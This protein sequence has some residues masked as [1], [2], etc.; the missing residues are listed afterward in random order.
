MQHKFADWTA[1]ALKEQLHTRVEIGSINVGFLNN[2]IVNDLYVEDLSHKEMLKVAR[3]SVSINLFQLI[4]N[5]KIAISTA[6]LFGTKANIY[7]QTKDGDF[8][9]QFLADAFKSD[10][11]ESKPIHLQINSLIVR[12]ADFCYNLLYEPRKSSIDPNHLNIKN[13]GFNLS[14]KT[15]TPD[16]VN[17][18]LKR[19]SAKENNCGLVLKELSLKLESNKETSVLSGFTLALPKTNLN[20]DTLRLNH[21]NFD[22]DKSFSFELAKIAATICPSDFLFLTPAVE[23]ADEI[24]HL[25]TTLSGSNKALDINELCITNNSNTLNVDLRAQASNYTTSKPTVDISVTDISANASEIE[26]ITS[27]LLIDNTFLTPLFNA[28]NIRYTGNFTM[29]AGSIMSNG[30]LTT[31]AGTLAYEASMNGEKML[32]AS[33]EAK[34]INLGRMLDDENFGILNMNTEAL[35]DL[36]AGSKIPCGE[37][38]T[39]IHDFDYNGYKY[40]SINIDARNN[41]SDLMV[42]ATSADEN[43]EFDLDATVSNFDTATKSIIA[44]LNIKNLNLKH[45]NIAKNT[46]S[47][48]YSFNLSTKAQ[49]S[50]INNFSGTASADDITLHTKNGTQTI[51]NITLDAELNGS[52]KQHISIASSFIDAEVK[53]SFRIDDIVN[54]FQNVLSYHLPS[55][56]EKK[57][58]SSQSDITYRITYRD[59]ELLHHFINEEYSVDSPITVFGN[60]NSEDHTLNLTCNAPKLTLGTNQLSNININC[61]SSPGKLML[62]FDGGN[63]SDDATTG[64]KIIAIAHKDRVD[65]DIE[66]NNKAKNDLSLSLFATTSFSKHDGLLKT[67]VNIEKSLLCINN[68]DWT[69]SPSNITYSDK[70]VECHNFK[71]SS[72]AQYLEIDGKASPDPGD[73][74]IVKLND[75]EVAYILDLVNFHSVEFG[76]KASGH[77]TM[78]N[79][80]GKPDANAML[81]VQNFTLEGGVMGDANIFARWDKEKDGI[82]VN[83]HITDS[84]MHRIGLS[85]V[86]IKTNG[87]TDVNG[88]ILPGKEELNLDVMTNNTRTDFLTGFIGDIFNDINGKVNGKLNVVGPFEDIN[89]IGDVTADMSFKLAATKVPYVVS[90]DTVHLRYHEFAFEDIKLHDKQNNVGVLNGL[91]THHNLANFTYDFKADFTNLCAY[92]E[93]EFN[94]DKYMAQVWANGDIH[95]YGADGHPMYIDANV[96]PCKGSVFAYDSATPDALIS[97]SF[98]D[99]HDITATANHQS[100]NADSAPAENRRDSQTAETDNYKY[101]GDLYMNINAEL[102]PN[103]EIKLRMDNSKDG[104]ISTFGNGM[105]QAK[106]YNKGSFQ[107]FGNYNITSGKYRLYLQDLVFRNLDIQ[108]GSKVEFNGNPFDANIHLICKHEISS[109]PLSDLTATKAFSSN[110]KAKVDCYLDITG[111]LNNMNLAFSFEL[112]NVNEE[113][114]QLVRSMINSEEEMNKQMIYLLGFQRFYPTDIA[115]NTNANYG[116]QAVN[117]L[118]SSTISGQINQM[119]SNM[120]GTQSKWNFGTGITT[121]ENGWQD[122]DV[123]GMLSGR[124]LNDRLLINGNFGYRDNALTNTASFIGDFEVKYR[125]WENYDFYVKAYNQTNDR[126]FTKATLNTQGVGLS[127]QHDFEKYTIFNFL[128]RKRR[129]ENDSISTSAEQNS[130]NSITNSKAKE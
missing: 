85:D 100:H 127:F 83:A 44:A 54:N 43:I 76:G 58:T 112:P 39:C 66:L 64:G 118:L 19:L 124:L 50:D 29:K 130:K 128:K 10:N 105:F 87:V 5:G 28:G 120:I 93:T 47:E 2:I 121:G 67:N 60:L 30:T 61:S 109:V 81:F 75:I 37:V 27:L 98:I 16:S 33:L 24:I 63:K 9:F 51:E 96:S 35:I 123:E 49:F 69:I 125:I 65:A 7:K 92:N 126:Y 86:E 59:S 95:I 12:H 20:I 21:S 101:L 18:A 90:G 78:N 11:E 108:N 71:I 77:A 94:S 74:L 17:I 40:S 110:N 23:K 129:V 31:E 52:D 122:L 82:S 107:L 22:K 57:N 36:S 41:H 106:Y 115:Q 46:L 104:Y 111:N 113:M 6:Q 97:N 42:K 53:G 116:T 34:D 70:Q 38:N 48:S 117:S 15:F 4:A 103:C 80:F 68:D 1:R 119:L 8:N 62:T 3:V 114:R 102:N 45:L 88:Y 13:A 55:L 89:I 73:S 79:I 32:N 99:F 72:G 84:Y 56:I 25:S 26:K 14:L 91:I